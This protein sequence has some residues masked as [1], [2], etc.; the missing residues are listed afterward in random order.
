MSPDDDRTTEA[1][2]EPPSAPAFISPYGPAA[3]EPLDEPVAAPNGIPPLLEAAGSVAPAYGAAPPHRRRPHRGLLAAGVVAVAGTA[4]IGGIAWAVASQPREPRYDDPLGER[5]VDSASP[6]ELGEEG[7]GHG[8]AVLAIELPEPEQRW[9]VTLA[10][11]GDAL[12]LDAYSADGG[13]L[14]SV[15]S[16][17]SATG[18]DYEGVLLGPDWLT[19]TKLLLNIETD[20]DWTLRIEPLHA[21]P[22]LTGTVHG[23]FDA[24]Y[25]WSGPS[26]TARIEADGTYPPTIIADCETNGRS[27]W[28][29]ERDTFDLP[30]RECV[31]TVEYADGERWT[32]T[33]DPAPS[34]E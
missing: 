17:W 18:D 16:T 20:G 30:D 14:S 19:E 28:D 15:A 32:M 34:V 9:I 7:S 29:P 25:R 21:A 11:D 24:V 22:E 10:H 3:P 13:Y 12:E 23:D 5:A 1:P 4:V 26:A 6:I 8:H 2:S 31:V 33:V 27:E